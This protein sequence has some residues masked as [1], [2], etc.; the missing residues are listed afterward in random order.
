MPV[1]EKVGVSG[2]AQLAWGKCEGGF[3]TCL[4]VLAELDPFVVFGVFLLLHCRDVIS[5]CSSEIHLSDPT[6]KLKK[7]GRFV[8]W[9]SGDFAGAVI[10]IEQPVWCAGMIEK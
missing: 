5:R 6:Y 7:S 8:R 9:C 4:A 10:A 2:E 3:L 1:V